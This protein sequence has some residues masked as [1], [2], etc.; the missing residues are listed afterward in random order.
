[1]LMTTVKTETAV[2][3]LNP[4]FFRG[5]FLSEGDAAFRRGDTL[6]RN[7]YKEDEPAFAAW[8]TGWLDASHRQS[9]A[10][11]LKTLRRRTDVIR[12]PH[13]SLS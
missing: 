12:E 8:R 1:M 3:G 5:L 10:A 4:G 11:G 6:D 13:P 2:P 7:P 9:V